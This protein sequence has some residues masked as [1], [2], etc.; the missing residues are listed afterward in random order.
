MGDVAEA[1]LATAQAPV[2]AGLDL[3]RYRVLAGMVARGQ[4]QDLYD[5]ADGAIVAVQGLVGDADTHLGHRDPGQPRYWSAMAA[6]SRLFS[7]IISRMNSCRP[8]FMI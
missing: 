3:P 5:R 4:P 6:P 1:V 2:C 8:L 7:A